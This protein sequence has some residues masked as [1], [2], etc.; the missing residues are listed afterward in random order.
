MQGLLP[1][2]RARGEVHKNGN[3]GTGTPKTGGAGKRAREPW[4]RR[5]QGAQALA[6]LVQG[7]PPSSMARGAV[8]GLLPLSRARARGQGLGSMAGWLGVCRLSFVDR[9]GLELHRE[10]PLF[11][12]LRVGDSHSQP[13]RGSG[14]FRSW[15]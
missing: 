10:R 12:E 1:L 13:G 3:M 15:C 11:N 2:S 8:Q 7:L 9:I 5:A 4:A 6:G 14:V